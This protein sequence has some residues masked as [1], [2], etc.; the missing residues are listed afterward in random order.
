M[1]VFQIWEIYIVIVSRTKAFKLENHRIINKGAYNKD[2]EPQQPSMLH[3]LQSTSAATRS[4]CSTRPFP[5]NQSIELT[6][7]LSIIDYA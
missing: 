1:P 4:F 7:Y 3:H 5:G 2:D 6:I